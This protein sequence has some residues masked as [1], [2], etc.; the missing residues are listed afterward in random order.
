MQGVAEEQRSMGTCLQ[1]PHVHS[2]DHHR[3]AEKSSCLH[4][5]GEELGSVLLTS[6]CT[7]LQDL[8][9]TFHFPRGLVSFTGT[10]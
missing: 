3:A 1:N 8:S 2:A 10:Q 6:W 7:F 5:F 4:L 9:F